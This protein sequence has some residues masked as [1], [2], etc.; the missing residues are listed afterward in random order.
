M[1]LVPR[2]Y[3]PLGQGGSHP[4]SKVLR[5]RLKA[6]LAKL[7]DSRK[8][9]PVVVEPSKGLDLAKESRF[10]AVLTDDAPHARLTEAGI[11]GDF[12]VHGVKGM[13]GGPGVLVPHKTAGVTKLFK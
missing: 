2:A 9:G 1:N 4:P 5:D 8:N 7:V 13:H 12:H 3:S 10:D 6:M 11:V